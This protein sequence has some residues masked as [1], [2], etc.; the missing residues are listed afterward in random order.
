[1]QPST[2]EEEQAWEKY[3]YPSP[4]TDRLLFF[5]SVT[6]EMYNAAHSSKQTQ[7]KNYFDGQ[8]QF[9]WDVMQDI[10][11]LDEII[12]LY[13]QGV[14]PKKNIELDRYVNVPE[15]PS[16]KDVSH[17]TRALRYV[18]NTHAKIDKL[19]NNVKQ[20]NFAII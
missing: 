9:R 20:R 11:S 16:I 12:H 15:D 7:F 2:I 14:V 4:K 19:L 13:D 6:A 1:M 3:L 10:K 8:H 18:M 17:A 5:N